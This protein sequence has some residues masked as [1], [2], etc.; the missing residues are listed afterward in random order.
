[1][2]NNN[3]YL[4][5]LSL[6]C[7]DFAIINFTY[8]LSY[9]ITSLISKLHQSFF[10]ETIL[11]FN[12]SWLASGLITSIYSNYT[13]RT[14]ESVLRST[15]QTSLLHFMFFSSFILFFYSTHVRFNLLLVSAVLLVFLLSMSRIYLTY[16]IEF[17]AK[18]SRLNKRIAIVGHNEM[19]VK[20]AN[21]FIDH[22]S[23]YLIVRTLTFKISIFRFL[24][25]RS[26]NK[27]DPIYNIYA[28]F[29][30]YYYMIKYY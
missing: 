8:F 17:I 19:G 24:F 10:I 1:M 11:A 25:V 28:S 22:T 15:I 20:L 16:I 12:I 14:L 21:Y 2:N 4:L 7:S 27:I 5:K 26:F 29:Y 6:L 3:T 9:I 30:V 23:I 18:K 13:M